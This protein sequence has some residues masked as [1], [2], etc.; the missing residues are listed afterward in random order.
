MLIARVRVALLGAAAALVLV[1]CASVGKFKAEAPSGV[2][3][4]GNWLLDRDASDDPQK[5]LNKLRPKPLSQDELAA[6]AAADDTQ[7]TSNGGQRG[8]RRT[9]QTAPQ[10]SYRNADAYTRAPVRKMVQADAARGE[11]LTVKQAPNAV[12]LDYGSMVRNFTPGEISV[13]SAEW[14]V[15]DQSSGWQGKEFVIE[16]RPQTGV[17]SI[18]KYGLSADGKHLIVA[19]HLGGNGF[20]AADLKQVYDRTDR[21]LPRSLPTND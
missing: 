3:L 5:V 9:Q 10:P 2:D 19:L 8:G 4:S 15:A 18:E 12:T 16:T 6:M 17:A 20:P 14:G 21:P 11:Q 13:V 1:G 7:T